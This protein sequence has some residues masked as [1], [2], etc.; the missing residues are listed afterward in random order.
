VID[1]RGR[2]AHVIDDVDTKDHAE[3]VLALL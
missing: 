1:E 2:V 3:Q